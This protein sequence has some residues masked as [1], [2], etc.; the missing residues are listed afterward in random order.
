MRERAIVALLSDNTI[1]AAAERCGLNEK[2]LRVIEEFFRA[3]WLSFHCVVVERA[4]VKKKLHGGDLDVA[5]RKH[6]TML[7]TNKVRACMKAHPDRRQTFRIWTDPIHSRYSKADEA[8]EVI[9]NNALAKAFGGRSD[10]W[11]ALSS[12]TL[13]PHPASSFAVSYWAQSPPPGGLRPSGSQLDYSSGSR[14]TWV[15][16]ISE[17]IHDRPSGSST[18]GCF[19]TRRG[20]PDGRSRV[21]CD[22]C[23]LCLPAR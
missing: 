21:V 10:P 16:S 15:R 11:T 5:R 19:T 22:S 14:T 17:V 20:A 2:T 4:I 12:E 23:F 13:K 8:L 9:A 18:C 1:G 3:P 6:L 7:L